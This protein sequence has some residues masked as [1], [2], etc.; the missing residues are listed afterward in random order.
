LISAALC[1]QAFNVLSKK[2]VSDRLRATFMAFFQ[3]VSLPPPG[4]L[5]E[6]ETPP[7]DKTDS[8]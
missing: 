2:L 5:Q 1:R 3:I 6:S 7:P 4:G 8:P